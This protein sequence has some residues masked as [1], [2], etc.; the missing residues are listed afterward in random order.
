MAYQ[1]IRDQAHLVG[2]TASRGCCYADSF[3]SIPFQRMPNVWLEPGR[4]GKTLDD[5][6]AM[7]DDGILIDG[8]GSYS[9]DQ[10]RY[11]FQ[12][13]GDAFWEIKNG[14]RG[15]MLADVAYQSKTEEFWGACSAIAGEAAWVNYG[16]TNDGKGQ[17]SQSN[18]MSHGCAPTLFRGIRVLRTE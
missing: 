2:E 6:I 7:V 12:F 5:L 15:R 9:I 17:P 3:D 8:R 13:G 1:T 4:D 16:L 10:Q 18:A 11:N 14:K